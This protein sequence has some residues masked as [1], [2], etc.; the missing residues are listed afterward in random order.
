MRGIELTSLLE[1]IESIDSTIKLEKANR[2]AELRLAYLEFYNK[3]RTTLRDILEYTQEEKQQEVF[4]RIDE[5]KNVMNPRLFNTEVAESYCIYAKQMLKE[6]NL[7]ELGEK[8]EI[9][10][11]LEE[12]DDGATI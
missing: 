9:P 7:T 10:Y 6:T 5:I 2:G 1:K 8:D 12:I 4:D 11:I 3:C